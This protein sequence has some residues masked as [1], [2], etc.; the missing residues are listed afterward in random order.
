M[1]NKG[2]RAPGTQC[3]APGDAIAL[4]LCGF[5]GERSSGRRGRETWGTGVSAPPRSKTW[6]GIHQMQCRTRA[7]FAQARD[8]AADD[9]SRLVNLFCACQ[10]F[11]HGSV[12][13]QGDRHVRTG[14]TGRWIHRWSCNAAPQA[15]NLQLQAWKRR[16]RHDCCESLATAN[17]IRVLTMRISHVPRW[18]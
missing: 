1:T 7:S 18:I 12:T 2:R 5:R 6:M 10:G 16:P 9:G 3:R 8:S 14:E 11:R 15:L 17:T 4:L 13:R